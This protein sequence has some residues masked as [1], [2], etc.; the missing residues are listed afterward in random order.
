MESKI[1]SFGYS[2]TQIYFVENEVL[3]FTYGNVLKFVYLSS[4]HTK[5]V[6]CSGKGISAFA[7]NKKSNVYGYAEKGQHPLLH[8]FSYPSHNRIATLEG[9]CVLE[10]VKR[11]RLKVYKAM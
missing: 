1:Y 5:H 11:K 7:F 6:V 2:G 8:L 9:E 10:W 4:G 3:L